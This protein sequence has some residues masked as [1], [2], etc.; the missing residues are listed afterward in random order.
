[1]SRVKH[2]RRP[3]TTRF[4]QFDERRRPSRLRQSSQ[5]DRRQCFLHL[6]LQGVAIA[7]L[8][9]IGRSIAGAAASLALFGLGLRASPRSPPP[10]SCSTATATRATPPSPA[11]RNP[12]HHQPS[13][14]TISRRCSRH[15]HRLPA[16]RPRRRCRLRHRR[17]GTH[18]HPPST[19][20]RRL[21]TP[22]S[23]RHATCQRLPL[24]S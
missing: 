13:H 19:S 18:A 14:R 8:P 2:S 16:T 5:R 1:M 11:S 6:A 24:T 10:R 23:P 12:H 22:P 20:R 7:A 9:F 4:S 15:D 17:S 3:T 21:T